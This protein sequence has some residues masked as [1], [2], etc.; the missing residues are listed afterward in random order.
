MPNIDHLKSIKWTINGADMGADPKAGPGDSVAVAPLNDFG[1][2]LDST[3]VLN[4]KLDASLR[5]GRPVYGP[6]GITDTATP[7]PTTSV[8]QG[9]TLNGNAIAGD[10]LILTFTASDQYK[11][12]LSETKVVSILQEGSAGSGAKP[13]ALAELKALVVSG[14]EGVNA[15]LDELDEKYGT[16]R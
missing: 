7:D 8:G 4:P 3:R 6:N 15:R 1:D 11:H 13:D 14:F 12:S 10:A 2:I 16:A 9:F 5:S